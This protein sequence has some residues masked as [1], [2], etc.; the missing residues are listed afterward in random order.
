[1]SIES[2]I[3]VVDRNGVRYGV[4]GSDLSDKLEANDVLVSNRNGVT[5]SFTY[6]GDVSE[7]EDTDLF[8]CT[9]ED[10]VTKTVTGAQFKGMFGSTSLTLVTDVEW[11]FDADNRIVIT[12]DATATDGGTPIHP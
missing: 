7:I 2:A 9:D 10:G 11:E 6:T 12:K 5:N 1:M 3:F 8:V 4:A